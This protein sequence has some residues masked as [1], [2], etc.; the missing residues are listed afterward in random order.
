R[1][2]TNSALFLG[3]VR[4]AHPQMNLTCETL[5]VDFPRGGG[6]AERI[7]AERSVEFD[8][9]DD[10]GQK[11]HGTGQKALYTYQVTAAGTNDLV[12]LTGNPL[13]TMTNGSTF[14]NSVIILDRAKSKLVAPGKYLIR[15]L[16][17]A[18][19]AT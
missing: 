8:L 5:A 11:I 9:M 12:E 14:Q 10:K 3:Q 6:A 2:Q 16:G 7:V 17:T 13:L 4:V 15:G 1:L 18:D 19:V